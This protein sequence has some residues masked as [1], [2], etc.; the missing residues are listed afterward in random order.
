MKGRRVSMLGEV[1]ASIRGALESSALARRA[2]NHAMDLLDEANQNFI[3]IFAEARDQEAEQTLAL[4]AY[5]RSGLA[6]T[7]RILIE[8]ENCAQR[9]RD[10]LG[11]DAIGDATVDAVSRPAR[12]QAPT[13]VTLSPGVPPTPERIEQLRD[14]LPPP[15]T[16][17][18]GR[19]TYGRWVS[20]D[21]QEHVEV[22]GRD[23]KYGEAIRLFK[24]MRARRIPSRASDV[25][26][27]L[28]AHMR[29]NGIRSV[30]LVVNH[31]PARGR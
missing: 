4:L 9:Y 10:S 28:A 6:D 15:V 29:K 7:Q 1:I 19:K 27:K 13:G 24:E 3:H 30:T 5:A 20:A 12:S 11:A 14:K 25:E 31:V 22:S 21:G 16:S 18:A 2:L 23:E 17:G 26:M 8:A